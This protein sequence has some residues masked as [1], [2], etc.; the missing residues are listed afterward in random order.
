MA[1]IGRKHK[2]SKQDIVSSFKH[3]YEGIKYATVKERNMHIHIL[4]A[5]LVIIFAA[6]FN[7]SYIEWIICLVL[8]GLVISLELINTA[9]EQVVD[10]ITTDENN[11]AKMAKDLSA[12]AV[13]VSAIISAI[14]GLNIF[15]PRIIEFLGM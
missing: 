7:I 11:Y 5:L 4:F 6:I 3:A 1:L 12:G 13:L 2:V 15:L 8:I 14:I 10:L 9:I